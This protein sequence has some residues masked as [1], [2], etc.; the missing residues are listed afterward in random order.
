MNAKLA[1]LSEI[2]KVLN[3]KNDKGQ[4]ISML[5]D[6]FGIGNLL[7]H[8]SLEKQQGTSAATLVLALCLFRIHGSSIFRAYMGRFYGLMDTGKNCFY[9]MM[10]RSSM[11]WR[12]LLLGI[13]YRFEVILRK[14]NVDN[15]RPRCYIIDDTTVEKTGKVME[16]VSRV[17]DHVANCCVLGYKTLILAICDGVSTL[18]VDFSIHREK[19]K[20]NDCGLSE[21]ERKAQFKLRRNPNNPDY[22]RAKECDMSKIDVA[23]EMLKR[24]WKHKIRASYVLADSWYTCESLISA[25]RKLGRGAVHYVGL[26]KLGKTRYLV[27]GK[28]HNAYELISLYERQAKQCRQYKCMYISLR[29]KLGSQD[30]RIF[31]IKYGRHSVWNIMITSDIKMKFVEAFKLYQMRWSIEVLIR[32]C[33]QH[34]GFGKFQG[35]NFDGQIADTT[36]CF[37]TYTILALALRFSEYETVGEIFRA[38]RE[39]LLALTLWDRILDCVIRILGYLVEIIPMDLEETLRGLSQNDGT[40]ENISFLAYELQKKCLQEQVAV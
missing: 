18:P 33:R 3:V 7:K 14:E 29:G 21:K 12:R 13:T 6:R 25:V 2:E 28:R 4:Q 40:M 15:D 8:L 5:F 10:E 9:R 19:G 20:K 34:L 36:L 39:Q 32:E 16:K 26:A 11:N 27:N 37:I 1:N 31:L 30:V 35:R 22:D 24:A 38:E 23:I 17:Y